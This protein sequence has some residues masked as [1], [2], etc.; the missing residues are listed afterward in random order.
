MWNSP[1][2]EPPT[3][4]FGTYFLLHIPRITQ[5][6]LSMILTY[7]F[8]NY[9]LGTFPVSGPLLGDMDTAEN[10][11]KS[12]PRRAPILLQGQI[13]KEYMFCI[14]SLKCVYI[15]ALVLCLEACCGLNVGV[16]PKFIC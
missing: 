11:T 16:T 5:E 9:I 6:N 10:E 15:L 7:V 2:G 3:R 8:N 14:K 4:L 1:Q 13:P 12:W